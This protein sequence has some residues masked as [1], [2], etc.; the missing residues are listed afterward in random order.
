L[1]SAT[2]PSDVVSVGASGTLEIGDNTFKPLLMFTVGKDAD[3]DLEGFV[4]IQRS[5]NSFEVSGA[6][7]MDMVVVGGSPGAPIPI[8]Q[9]T[10]VGD[11]QVFDIPTLLAFGQ[12]AVQTVDTEHAHP[13]TVFNLIDFQLSGLVLAPPDQTTDGPQVKLQGTGTFSNATLQ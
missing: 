12:S 1:L 8:W 3:A 5:K 6:A 10:N 9:Q 2:I 7:E 13:F 11:D 4:A